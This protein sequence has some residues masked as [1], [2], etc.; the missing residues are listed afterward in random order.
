MSSPLR[1]VILY[2]ARRN[3]YPV[4]DHNLTPEE[5][6]KEIADWRGQP[7][8]SAL[9]MDQSE[10]HATP[11]PQACGAC[12]HTVEDASGLNPKP[13]FKRMVLEMVIKKQQ[14]PAPAEAGTGRK[15]W[16][17]KSP[18]EVVIVQIDRVREGVAKREEDLKAARRELQKLD[19]AKKLLE[20]K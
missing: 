18:I 2:D 3:V 16:K 12:R 8:A 1:L 17:K 15:P 19:E 4:C 5:A 9:V 7:L 13:Q 14:G 20:A 6:E 11:N 10:R